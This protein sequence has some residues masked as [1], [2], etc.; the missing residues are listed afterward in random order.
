ML[1]RGLLLLGRH[2][3]GEELADQDCGWSTA[4]GR[5]REW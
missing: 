3:G 4:L 1:A 5:V 2:V